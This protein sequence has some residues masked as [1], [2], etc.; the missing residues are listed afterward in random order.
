MSPNKGDKRVMLVSSHKG[1]RG[2]ALFQST[3]QPCFIQQGRQGV[4]LFHS[5]RQVG[6]SS[7][8]GDRVYPCSS[9]REGIGGISVSSYRGR[10]GGKPCFIQSGGMW[11]PLFHPMNALRDI[12]VSSDKWVRAYPLFHP[13]CAPP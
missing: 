11:V 4:T 10:D 2:L 12:L 6:V 9:Y 13:I 5:T 7:N 3:R 8:K 1:N